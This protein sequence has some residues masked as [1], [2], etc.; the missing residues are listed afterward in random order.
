MVSPRGLVKSP[1]SLSIYHF[2]F[3]SG[4]IIISEERMYFYDNNEQIFPTRGDR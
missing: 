3:A 2:L 4:L 1:S